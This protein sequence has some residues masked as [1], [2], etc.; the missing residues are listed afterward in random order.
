MGEKCFFA[1]FEIEF[2]ALDVLF[3]EHWRLFCVNWKYGYQD[4]GE[5]VYSLSFKSGLRHSPYVF[6]TLEVI[7]RR[8]EIMLQDM[9]ENVYSPD[10]KLCLRYL[11]FY[12][13]TL[14]VI[15]ASIGD[16]VAKIRAK[17]FIRRLSYWIYNIC[18]F[19]FRTLEVNLHR[20]ELRLP[21]Y[22]RK[23]LFASFKLLL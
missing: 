21:R 1:S 22:G 2:K 14:K 20:L 13:R 5:T 9:D 17:T 11:R 12:F 8:L 16:T 4:N 15:F 6:W 10:L 3:F 18:R 19:I 7:L 23:H